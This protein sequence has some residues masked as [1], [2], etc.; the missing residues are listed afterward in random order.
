[1][2]HCVAVV[3]ICVL[4]L[5]GCASYTGDM[6]A[7]RV[8]VADVSMLDFGLIE[9]TLVLKLRIQNPNS[10]PIPIE[11]IS[12]DL[13][14]NGKL[15]AQGISHPQTQVPA[16]STA[17]IDTEAVSNVSNLFQQLG[18]VQ[19]DQKLSYHLKGKLYSSRWHGPHPFDVEGEISLPNFSDWEKKLN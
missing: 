7:L 2:H 4:A 18:Q 5:T 12:Y 14:L 19:K 11:G 9:Q 1:M 3:T 17:E 16:F 10:V 6:E 15:L 8:S 13:E